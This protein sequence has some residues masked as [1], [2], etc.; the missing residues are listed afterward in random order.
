MCNARQLRHRLSQLVHQ[1]LCTQLVGWASGNGRGSA[2]R[3][4]RQSAAWR[5]L[6]T[7]GLVMHANA[8]CYSKRG[9]EWLHVQNLPVRL[10]SM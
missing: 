6:L 10:L 2:R 5:L 4:P 9:L 1:L 7:G 8:D 3:C